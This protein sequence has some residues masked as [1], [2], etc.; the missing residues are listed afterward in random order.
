MEFLICYCIITLVCLQDAKAGLSASLSTVIV[1]VCQI[2]STYAS[3][4]LI[5]RLG[6]KPLLIFSGLLMALS[7]AILGLYFYLQKD[8][9]SIFNSLMQVWHIMNYLLTALFLCFR[10]HQTSV[11]CLL[12]A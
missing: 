3:T 1:G 6:R 5:D 8:G 2:L 7:G 9:V 4:L 12:C 10:M 11:G